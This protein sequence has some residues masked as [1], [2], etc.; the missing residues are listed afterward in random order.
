MRADEGIALAPPVV[1]AILAFRKLSAVV[2]ATFVPYPATR[3]ARGVEE[4]TSLT[5]DRPSAPSAS[6]SAIDVASRDAPTLNVPLDEAAVEFAIDTAAETVAEL[7]ICDAIPLEYRNYVGHVA[8]QYSEQLNRKHLDDVAAQLPRDR[9]VRTSRLAFHNP[10]PI[11]AAIEV[12]QSERRIGLLV[13]GPERGQLGRWT[14]RRA[15]SGCA[16]QAPC[17]VWTNE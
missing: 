4:M 14:F 7:Y 12:A 16:E 17:L 9:G 8:R 11:K 13:F 1:P 6:R 15:A 10:K 5:R 2:H 3:P